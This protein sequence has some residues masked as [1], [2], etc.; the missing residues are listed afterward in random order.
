MALY[1]KAEAL[2][3]SGS[4]LFLKD[5]A[6]DGRDLMALGF[7]EGPAVGKTL[8]HLLDQVI[9]GHHKNDRAALLSAAQALLQSR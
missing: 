1:E 4:C 7:K 8:R 9:E 6:I 2:I 3:A 5:L